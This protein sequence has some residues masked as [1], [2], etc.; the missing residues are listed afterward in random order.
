MSIIRIQAHTATKDFLVLVADA[1]QN[2]TMAL[3][4]GAQLAVDLHGYLIPA[5]LLPAFQRFAMIYGLIVADERRH[6]VDHP[7]VEDL[8]DRCGKPEDQCENAAG[9]RGRFKDHD[10][11]T[12][13]QGELQRHPR[14]HA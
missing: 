11:T 12:Q 3:F 8:C 2:K 9:N 13:A 10:F 1:S 14:R 7:G 4:E 5:N 6:A